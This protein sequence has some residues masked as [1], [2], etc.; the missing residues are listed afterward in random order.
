MI[1]LHDDD[2]DLAYDGDDPLG[3]VGELAKVAGPHNIRV[4]DV[5]LNPTFLDVLTGAFR[6]NRLPDPKPATTDLPTS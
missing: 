4:V 1:Y 5:G 6:G 2:V 3:L